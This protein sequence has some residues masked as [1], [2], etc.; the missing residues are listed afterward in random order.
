MASGSKVDVKPS[1]YTIHGNRA[2]YFISDRAK[3]SFDKNVSEYETDADREWKG[4][5]NE[6]PRK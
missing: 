1:L 4:F 2:H 5:S 3:R 6:D